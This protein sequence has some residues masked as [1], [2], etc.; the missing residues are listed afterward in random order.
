MSKTGIVHN[1][2]EY[3]F[4]KPFIWM[5]LSYYFPTGRRTLGK[6]FPI[7]IGIV[8]IQVNF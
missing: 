2:F 3:L 7:T 4:V 5:T 8:K 1:R 6:P